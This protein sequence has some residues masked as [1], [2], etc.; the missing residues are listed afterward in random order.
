MNQDPDSPSYTRSWPQSPTASTW[1]WWGGLLPPP[2]SSSDSSCRSRTWSWG[3]YWNVHGRPC[4]P[5]ASCLRCPVPWGCACLSCHLRRPVLGGLTA[6]VWLQPRLTFVG[7]CEY[8]INLW[9]LHPEYL[10]CVHGL[11]EGKGLRSGVN[12]HGSSGHRVTRIQIHQGFHLM[13]GFSLWS[14]FLLLLLWWSF[15]NR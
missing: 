9:I 8:I 1:P 13:Q 10:L 6:F 11:L 5:R 4:P 2:C 15:R 7:L 3:S 12:L 14:D